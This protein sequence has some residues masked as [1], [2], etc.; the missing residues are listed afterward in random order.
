MQFKYI[1]FSKN[2]KA[3]S[4]ILVRLI[5]TR[6]YLIVQCSHRRKPRAN[7]RSVREANTLLTHFVGSVF[8]RGTQ[9]S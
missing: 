7:H 2:S 3:P 6:V 8:Q 4:I 1:Y 9:M 5:Q